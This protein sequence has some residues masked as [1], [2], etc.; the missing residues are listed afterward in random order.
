MRTPVFWQSR[1]PAALLLPLS[2]LFG[3]VTTVRRGLYRMGWLKQA[4]IPVPVVVVGNITA[5]GAGKTPTVQYLAQAL[6]ARGWHPGIIS[7]GYGGQVEGVAAVPLDGAAARY[8][9]EPLL[10]AQ[11]T[12]CPVMVG[13]QR[14]EAA[15]TLLNRSPDVDVILTDDGLQHYALARDIEL[16]VID[17]AR[18][19][20][21]GWLLPAGPLREPADRLRSTDA[22]IVNGNPAMALPSR[23]A[24]F[25]MALQPEDAWCLGRPATRRPLPS[26]I[27][28][29]VAAVAGIAHPPRFFDM[30][31]Q[32]GLQI[33][34]HAYPDHHAYSQAECASWGSGLIL[35]TEKDAVKLAALQHNGSIW[36]IPVRPQLQPDLGQWLHDRLNTL[37]S[38]HGRK[39][40]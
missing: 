24:R 26:F 21:N 37:R 28:E 30:L 18:G 8:G 31:R 13:R 6:K 16:V 5:G 34:A 2:L 35:T 20:Q 3:I 36:V 17:G 22:L 10:L 12:G 40:T 9:D 39:T 11:T 4:H 38:P 1:F 15:M 33:E 7:R 29:P 32:A 23:T 25:D 14:A 27:G 19:L